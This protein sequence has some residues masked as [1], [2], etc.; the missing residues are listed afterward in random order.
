[1]LNQFFHIIRTQKAIIEKFMQTLFQT[2][3]FNEFTLFIVPL[4]AIC[5]NFYYKVT[6]S[7]PQSRTSNLRVSSMKL[8]VSYTI[9]RTLVIFSPI[10]MD[11]LYSR[12]SNVY[13]NRYRQMKRHFP[14]RF[15][16]LTQTS[17]CETIA[18]QLIPF[19]AKFEC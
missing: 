13:A 11:S 9:C 12:L 10:Y 7:V 3:I 18:R 4:F 8:C 14:L 19:K 15:V 16:P 1:M 5:L 17:K 6:F 2:R